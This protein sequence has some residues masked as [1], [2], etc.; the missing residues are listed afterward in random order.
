METSN[1]AKQ[2]DEAVKVLRAGGIMLYPTDTVWGIGCDAENAE[3]VKKIYDLKQRSDSKS[4]LVLVDRV[5]RILSYIHT[6]PEIAY[7]LLEVTDT[8]LTIIY[9]GARNLAPNLVP[10]ENT[11]GIRVVN[12]E[13][14]ERVI[15]KLNR[16]LVSTSANLSGKPAPSYFEEI[17]DEIVK[18]VDYA[19]SQEF[20]GMPT[21]KPS[22]IIMLGLGGE[23]KIIRE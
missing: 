17:S 8:P 20:E 12:H 16:P 7:S 1:I 21:G 14:C 19:V 10:P 13:F 22:S 6:M 4:M 2:V 18:G 5:E 11:V 9:P 3:A 23:V 15:K